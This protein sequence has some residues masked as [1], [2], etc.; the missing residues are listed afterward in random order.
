MN[1]IFDDSDYDNEEE[2]PPNFGLK[3]YWDK[4]YIEDEPNYDWFFSWSQVSSLLAKYI[5]N[6]EET[7]VLGC[8]NST[9]SKELIDDGFNF[10]YSIDISPVVVE[11]MQK[12]YKNEKQLRWSVMNCTSLDYFDNTFDVVFDKGTLDAILCNDDGEEMIKQS[13]IE[14][15]RVLKPNGKF[16]S[17]TFDSPAKRIKILKSIKLDWNFLPPLTIDHRSECDTIFY[18]YIFEKTSTN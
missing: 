15:H 7:L 6:K 13:L 1:N 3:D 4:R 10:V 5:E 16:I 17:I 8:G 18:A 2:E 12:M 9:M 14:V 11:K